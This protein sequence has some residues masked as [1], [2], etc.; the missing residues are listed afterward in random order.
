MSSLTCEFE[1]NGDRTTGAQT[2]EPRA[3]H[4]WVAGLEDLTE[5]DGTLSL[6][7]RLSEW[8]EAA[9]VSDIRTVH[10]LNTKANTYSGQL[11]IFI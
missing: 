11:H 1:N 2:A 4:H 3:T 8:A 5:Q 6:C 10:T 9:G 7:K